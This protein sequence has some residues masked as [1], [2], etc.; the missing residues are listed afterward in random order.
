MAIN[1]DSNI[2]SKSEFIT[3]KNSDELVR[4]NFSDTGSSLNFSRVLGDARS[5]VRLNSLQ[6]LPPDSTVVKSG[7]TLSG[8]V[9]QFLSSRGV[10][11]S[12]SEVQRLAQEVAQ[13][14][15]IQNA[16]RI[17]PGQRIALG[18]LH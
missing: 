6:S 14:S 11:P 7:D 2:L 3:Q 18:S 5:S 9:K 10:N 17:F 15:G 8:I 12:M 1:I 16:N 4:P 13:A